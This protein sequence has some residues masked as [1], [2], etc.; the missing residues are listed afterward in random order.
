MP[1][2]PESHETRLESLNAVLPTKIDRDTVANA[3]EAAQGNWSA[4]LDGLKGKLPPATLQKV[5]LAHTLA[6]W[7]NDHVPLV[8]ALTAASNVTSLRDVALQY[9]A[10]KLAALIHPDEM[11]TTVA[12]CS[13]HDKAKNFVLNLQTQ[14]FLSET[15]AVLQR[16]VRDSEVPIENADVRTGV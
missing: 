8:K 4:A 7:T 11:P 1:S 10:E 12:G 3:M 16:M 14:L 13:P 2:Q 6:E 5:A 15:S 9:N